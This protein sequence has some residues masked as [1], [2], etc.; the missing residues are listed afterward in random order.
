VSPGH[1]AL[2]NTKDLGEALQAAGGLRNDDVY[3]AAGI[4]TIRSKRPSNGSYYKRKRINL[5]KRPWKLNFRLLDGDTI[6][7]QFKVNSR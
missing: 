6:I 1:Y 4:I 5:R 3:Q 2:S 7:A